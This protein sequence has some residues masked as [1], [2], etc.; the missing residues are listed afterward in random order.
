MYNLILSKSILI[1]LPFCRN[2]LE[3]EKTTL[4]NLVRNLPANSTLMLSRL[5]HHLAK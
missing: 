3:T 4:A 2:L 1:T 5:D